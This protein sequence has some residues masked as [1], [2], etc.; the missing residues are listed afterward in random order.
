MSETSRKR[1]EFVAKHSKSGNGRVIII[2]PKEHMDAVDKLKNPL[3]VI[4]EEIL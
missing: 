4:V 2:I 3:H 1:M